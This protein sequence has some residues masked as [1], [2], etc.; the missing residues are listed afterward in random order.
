VVTISIDA[1]GGDIG[2][3]V[4]IAGAAKALSVYP[5]LKFHFF[6]NETEIKAKLRDFPELEKN[7]KISHTE[8]A[9]DM[10]DKPSSALRKGRKTSSMWQAIEAVKDGDADVAV[11]AGN[12]GALMAMA[13]FCLRTLP[14]I[15]RPA[16]AALWPTVK[17]ETVV[18]DVGATVGAEQRQLID[19]AF[20]GQAMARALYD[21]E[22]PKVGLLNIGVEEVKGL[23]EVKLAAAYMKEKELPF[24]YAGFIEGDG[25]GSGEV[26][27]VVT[28]GFAGNIA[29]KTAEGTAKQL[30]T[31]LKSAMT[32]TFSA[33]LGFFFARTAFTALRTV[34]DPR[35][36]NGGVFLG[37]NGLVIKSHGGTDASGFASAVILGHDMA[38]NKLNEKLQ[39]DLAIYRAVQEPKENLEAKQ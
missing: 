4:T 21:I 6:G 11:S 15:Q 20:M 1:M 25:I 16:I 29:L 37:L 12:T 5:E 39:N 35:K 3:P 14:S 30:S 33:M 28:E 18:L 23:D 2:I 9:I 27:V 36:M 38:V 10:A 7:S 26:D 19:N 22:R 31:Y 32:R 13:T 24:D 34:M 17:S 8:V